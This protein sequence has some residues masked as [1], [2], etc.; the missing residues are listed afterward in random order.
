MAHKIYDMKFSRIY[1]AYGAKVARKNQDVKLVDT[2]IMWL[3]GYSEEDLNV[4]KSSEVSMRTFFD[5]AIHMNDNTHLIKGVICGVRVED[6]E[7]PLMQKIRW[8][9]KLIDECAKGKHIDKILR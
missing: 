7:D 8:L 6:V 3:T 9:D 4:L 2:I 1:D 5:E